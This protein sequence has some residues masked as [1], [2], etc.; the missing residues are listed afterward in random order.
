MDIAIIHH[1][2]QRKGG[3]ERYLFDLLEGFA[4]QD[5]RTT[6]YVYKQ[7]LQQPLIAHSKVVKRSLNWLPRVLRKYYFAHYLAK[8]HQ[9]SAVDCTI[10]LMRSTSQELVVSGGTHCGFLAH[11]DKKPSLW[12]RWEIVAEQ[13]SFS[14]SKAIIAHSSMIANE[15]QRYYGI[16]PEKIH[17]LLPPINTLEFHLGIRA[18]REA[19]RRKWQI[20]DNRITLLFPSTGHKRKGLD[21]LLKALEQ[22]PPERYE[23][24]I[25]GDKLPASKLPANVRCLGFVTDMA[26]LYVA[27]DFTIMPSFYEPFGLV[28]PESLACGT[29]VIVS[30]YVGA[31]DLLTDDYGIV[32]PSVGV[33]AIK[34][35]IIHASQQTFSIPTDFAQR[36]NLTVKSHIDELKKVMLGARL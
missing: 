30:T 36:H 5:D 16:S 17:C 8:H 22:L 3:M 31:K 2:Y 35:A 11:T 32:M 25:A 14:S 4:A 20:Q 34:Q 29:P 15:I 26:E 21:P 7:D 9:R 13:K 19:Y 12:D 33:Q 18:N 1:Q 28:V 6:V 23:L 10:S 24:L 27:V